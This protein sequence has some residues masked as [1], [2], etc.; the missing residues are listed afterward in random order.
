M[1]TINTICETRIFEKVYE[2]CRGAY[3]RKL[4][5]GEACLSG[6]DLKG[7]AGKYKKRYLLSRDNLLARIE[8]EGFDVTVFTADNRK[9]VLV[10][11]SKQELCTFKAIIGLVAVRQGIINL[12]TLLKSKTIYTKLSNFGRGA[13][14]SLLWH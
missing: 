13:N 1:T 6:F 11:K 4:V 14:F 2:L 10:I 9:H 7:K 8:S 5:T 12:D 3:Q